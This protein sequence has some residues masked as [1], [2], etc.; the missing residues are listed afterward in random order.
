MSLV[1]IIECV[2]CGNSKSIPYNPSKI[3]MPWEIWPKGCPKCGS[4]KVDVTVIHDKTGR[5]TDAKI[6]KRK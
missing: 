4:Q 6:G 2:K 1:Q 3:Q 5:I